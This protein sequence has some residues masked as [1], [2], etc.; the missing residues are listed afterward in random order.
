MAPRGRLEL[1]IGF[2]PTSSPLYSRAQ[3]YAARHASTS[4]EVAPG[5]WRAAF[6]LDTAPEPYGR[7]WRLLGLVG[8]WRGTEVEVEGSPEP[9]APVVAMCSCAREWLRKVGACRASFPSG[10]WPKCERCPI[11][12]AG[13]AAESFAPSSLFGETFP[14]EGPPEL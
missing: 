6:S 8:A 10:A 5:V 11:Y 14:F 7:A 9:V 4:A 2:G 12:D 3:S 13:W 1:V